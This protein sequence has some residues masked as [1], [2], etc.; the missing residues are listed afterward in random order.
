MKR[1]LLIGGVVAVLLAAVV[2]YY[3]SSNPDGL[4][5]VAGDYGI[6]NSA[7]DSVTSGSPLADYSTT[8]VSNDR[9]SGAV[10]GLVG[11]AVT[12]AAAFGLF[13]AVRR[14]S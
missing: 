12:G 11:V 6:L 8:G 10:A 2:S 14:R 3:A 1:L 5:K 13:Y 7:Q 9:L 4:E